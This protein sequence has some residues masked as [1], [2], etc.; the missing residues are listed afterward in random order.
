M[1]TEKD[2]TLSSWWNTFVWTHLACSDSTGEVT[3]NGTFTRVPQVDQRG[4][5]NEIE[6]NGWTILFTLFHKSEWGS[7]FQNGGKWTR[8]GRCFNVWLFSKRMSTNLKK[9]IKRRWVKPWIM[10]CNIVGA[11]STLLDEWTSEDRD[12]YKN[13]LK[14]YREQFF[15][16][17]SKVKPYIEKQDTNMRECISAHVKL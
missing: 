11:S 8:A 13:H 7:R 1:K 10:R 14:M 17:L 12:M 5:I 16:L 3:S 2:C 6:F 15:E 4:W 9:K